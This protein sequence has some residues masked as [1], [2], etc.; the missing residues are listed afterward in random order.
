MESARGR[1]FLQEYA[2]RN[3]NADT[4]VVL[5]AIERIEAVI[6]GD[7]GR[8]A[9]L[10]FRSELLEMATTIAQTR[11]EVA[12]FPPARLGQAEAV[13]A[14]REVFAAAERIHEV[15]WTMRERGL[16]PST[17]DQIE[18]LSVSILSA[19]SLRDPNN[20]RAHM[21]GEVL[22]YLE[23]RIN[24]MLE[25]CAASTPAASEGNG[26]ADNVHSAPAGNGHDAFEPDATAPLSEPQAAAPAFPELAE[27][28]D[29]TGAA[30][31]PFNPLVE[32]SSAETPFRL[33]IEPL[34]FVGKPPAAV[35]PTGST[36][37]QSEPAIAQVET[38]ELELAPLTVVPIVRDTADAIPPA[39]ELEHA[40]IIVEAAF[41]PTANDAPAA[42]AEAA[43]AQDLPATDLMPE[44]VLAASAQ[45]DPAPAAAADQPP[46]E[47]AALEIAPLIA[48]SAAPPVRDDAPPVDI[49]LDPIAVEVA[50]P[51]PTPE[52]APSAAEP[53]LEFAAAPE[54]APSPATATVPPV[55]L[56][57]PAAAADPLPTALATAS[58][59]V[60]STPE[61]EAGH[62]TPS[63]TPAMT[64]AEATEAASAAA[65]IVPV[66]QAVEASSAEPIAA[67][68]PAMLL[69]E[70]DVAPSP[71]AAAVGERPARLIEPTIEEPPAVE[72]ESAVV[73]PTTLWSVPA[74]PLSGAGAPEPAL[75][76]ERPAPAIEPL[77]VPLA[78]DSA[79]A[80][81]PIA[82]E[83]ARPHAE[84]PAPTV[85]TAPA[86]SMTS[87]AASASPEPPAAPAP[88]AT[89]A[90]A[91][92]EA[93]AYQPESAELADF[94]LE[95][96][97]LPAVGGAATRPE[98][99]LRAASGMAPLDPMAEIEEE[100]FAAAPRA[101]SVVVPPAFD[102][103][104]T[105]RPSAPVPTPGAA[106]PAAGRTPL[107]APAAP[108]VPQ[109][110]PGDPL[111]A[112]K[113][114]T[115]EERIA[116]F[117]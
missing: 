113:A 104:A 29:E 20:G 71:A 103:A 43:S 53:A 57:A 24:A 61:P 111:A 69:P 46:G 33:E 35:G 77:I 17:C 110:T 96:L 72:V 93:P 59:L 19:S 94:L 13:A 31:A 51:E 80:E 44:P 38:I 73:A 54:D 76:V 78:A 99:G 41:A 75:S 101:P 45:P 63:S 106:V 65:P 32:P 117:T 8:E 112:L 1:W 82:T 22:R 115:D 89:A 97:P 109:P 16:D 4:R 26:A 25:S 68:A 47:M 79:M 56:D 7:R 91:E 95:P 9:Y 98:S 116:L 102:P 60:A 114:M 105:L 21:L 74:E 90:P 100:L 67:S 11:A 28:K 86:D 6:R 70:E 84:P 14:A 85:S 3:R 2:R 108:A 52:A 30:A 12:E 18:A 42:A 81:Q 64:S 62:S 36:E 15:A 92:P 27:A 55:E 66:E 23:R 39:A 107:V 58:E 83:A 49:E 34:A 48:T 10:S 87:N 50:R 37:P 5:D 40:P 88:D